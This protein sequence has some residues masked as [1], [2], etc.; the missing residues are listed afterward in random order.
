MIVGTMYIP[1]YT[2]LDMKTALYGRFQD[3][4]MEEAYPSDIQKAH[5]DQ[6]GTI[7][8]IRFGK[9]MFRAPV[10]RWWES[11]LKSVNVPPL[12]EDPFEQ[13]YVYVGKSKMSINSNILSIS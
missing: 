13:K 3:G 12:Q 10:Y 1:I 7:M 9:P 8:K 4:K 6:T 2:K 5:L 11:G